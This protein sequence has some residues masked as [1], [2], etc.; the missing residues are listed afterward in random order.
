MVHLTLLLATEVRIAGPAQCRDM[1]AV[2]MYIGKLKKMIR[3]TSHPEGSVAEGYTF[4]ESL[5][6]CSRN[7]LGCHTKLNRPEPNENQP[8]LRKIGQPPSAF[9]TVELDFISW[10]QAQRCV[11]FNYPK[12]N[13]YAQ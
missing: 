3:T 8:Y 9:T 12:I 7:L 2:E 5:T 1:W 4:D 6:Y 10:T 13:D 11:L